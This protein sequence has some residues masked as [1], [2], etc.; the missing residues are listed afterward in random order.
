[1]IDHR[2]LRRI[3]ADIQYL[4]SAASLAQNLAIGSATHRGNYRR[5]LLP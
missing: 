2:G 1:M 3:V 5:A 4:D